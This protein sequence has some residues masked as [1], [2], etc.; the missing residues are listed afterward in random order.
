MKAFDYLLTN[1][2][3]ISGI[4]TSILGV[5][6]STKQKAVA[7]IWS[8]IA[9]ILYGILFYQN[10]LYSDMELQGFFV[11]MAVFGLL[12]WKKNENSWKPQKSPINQLIMGIGFTL[13]F[14]FISGYLHQHYSPNVSFPYVDSSL[15]GLSIWGTWL[16]ANKKI[17][18]WIVWISADIVYTGMYFQKELYMTGILY[19]IFVLL[20]IQGLI[21]WK[22]KM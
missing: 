15:T 4:I 11:L 13:L 10:N 22:K 7:W 8:I 1:G 21:S 20:A 3:E 12:N 14:G 17:E 2:I 6:F 9:S 18:N 19:L 5:Y 16:A